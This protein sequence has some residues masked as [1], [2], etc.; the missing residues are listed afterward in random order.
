MVNFLTPFQAGQRLDLFVGD[1]FDLAEGALLLAAENGEKIKLNE[2]LSL[3]DSLA[4]EAALHLNLN[5]APEDI[6]IKLCFFF[7]ELKEFSGNTDDF[8]NADNSY[9]NKVLSSRQGIPISFAVLYLAVAQRLGIKMEGV[10]F[11]GHF[12]LQMSKEPLIMLD[13]FEH[14]VIT[15]EAECEERLR[16]LF[17]KHAR[18]H[19]SYLTP[20]NN[21]EIL[22]NM[23]R[24][25][26]EIHQT[27]ERYDLALTCCSRAMFF[28][29]D[30]AED[31]SVRAAL[32]EKLD[33]HA[34]AIQ[35]Y[36]HFIYLNPQDDQVSEFKARIR[37]LKEQG[38][39]QLVH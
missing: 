32:F 18:L 20:L 29:P 34:A 22:A 33:C 23:A 37:G 9:L 28:D 7:R 36:A 5:A 30:N 1:D 21:K 39:P 4:K 19:E 25:L 11:P 17:G 10:A 38:L 15:S 35:D 24:N 27:H 12:L 8:Y 6:A 16:K 13:P 31:Y 3:I 14:K 26:V 2:T